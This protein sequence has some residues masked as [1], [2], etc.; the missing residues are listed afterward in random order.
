M[1]DPVP[2]PRRT[3]D[4]QVLTQF[5]NSLQSYSTDLVQRLEAGQ[6][7]FHYTSLEGAIG[8]IGGGDLWLTNSRFSTDDEELNLG[9]RVVEEILD[10]MDKGADPSRHA[11]LRQLRE[12]ISETR[13]D[14]VYFCCFCET[15]NLL[16]Q[17]RGYAENGGGVSIEFDPAGFGAIAGD[18][19][20]HGLMRLW[21][22]FYN[23]EQQREIVRKCVNYPYW[24]TPNE[25]DRI[26]YIVDA[27][28]FFMPTFKNSDFSAENE[29]RLIFTPFPAAAVKPSFRN[30]RSLLVP[31][32]KLSQLTSQTF[33]LPIKGILIGPSPYSA[34][35]VESTR[36]MLE[37]HDYAGVQVRASTTPYRG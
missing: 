10:E 30:R 15:D 11:W 22:V 37:T 31:Y 14:H 7:L 34:L 5:L 16:S 2:T 19:S 18:D 25:T 35:N 23:G 12:K 33:K 36:V 13:V 21:R 20:A 26:S 6:N 24:P 9:Y 28:Q 27:L 3:I 29:R 32:V 4:I 1:D 8:I 17:W